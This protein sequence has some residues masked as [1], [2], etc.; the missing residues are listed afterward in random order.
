MFCN[1]YQLLFAVCFSIQI[2]IGKSSILRKK[3]VKCKLNLETLYLPVQLVSVLR[4]EKI[5]EQTRRNPYNIGP[6]N[7]FDPF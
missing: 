7:D 1:K 3:S 6:K 2:G 5:S 4:R